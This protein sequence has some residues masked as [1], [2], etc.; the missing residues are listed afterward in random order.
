L[1]QINGILETTKK[2]MNPKIA[3]MD[4]EGIGIGIDEVRALT[5]RLASEIISLDVYQMLERS[6]IKNII[7]EQNLDFSECVGNDCAIEM[8]KLVGADRMI[9][10]T[11]SKIGDTYSIDSRMIEVESGEAV[12]SAEFSTQNSIDDVITHGMES[13]SYQLCDMAV[14]AHDKFHF[15]EYLYDNK[16]KIALIF[17]TF[18]IGWGLLPA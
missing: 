5:Q 14:P 18:W 4:F 15:K 9:V 1:I 2:I 13:I 6:K 10:G 17:L 3:I 7:K 16:G 12:I 8:G 11:V